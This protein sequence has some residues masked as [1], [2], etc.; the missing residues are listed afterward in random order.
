MYNAIYKHF[1]FYSVI[2]DSIAPKCR[3]ECE[4]LRVSLYVSPESYRQHVQGAPCLLT[5]DSWDWLQHPRNH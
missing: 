5:N 3:N 4:R 1:A 2:G